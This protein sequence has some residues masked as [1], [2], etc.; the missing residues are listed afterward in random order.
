MMIE[1]VLCDDCDD[2]MLDN[3]VVDDKL[4]TAGPEM[5]VS[6]LDKSV[7]DNNTRSSVTPSMGDFAQLSDDRMR[8]NDVLT[9]E[10]GRLMKTEYYDIYYEQNEG[11]S[12]NDKHMMSMKYDPTSM[13]D[14]GRTTTYA[15]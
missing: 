11:R 1:G 7:L 13:Y 15:I 5:T 4:M 8:D 14:D 9:G 6:V 2:E 10:E 12:Y 3:Q